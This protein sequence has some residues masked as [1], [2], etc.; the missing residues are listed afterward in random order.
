MRKGHYGM[1]FIRAKYGEEEGGWATCVV[2][3][4][5]EPGFWKVIRK[6]G[7]FISN[8]MSFVVGNGQR[9]KFWKDKWCDDTPL[10]HSSPSLIAISSSK[11]AWV[12][13]IC[14]EVGF[15]G[16]WDPIFFRNLNYWEV[17]VASLFLRLG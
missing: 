8:K 3:I 13:D 11:E 12:R 14:R 10:C 16:H 5:Y 15:G 9:V 1:D 6:W 7:Y 2:R 4:G 17:E